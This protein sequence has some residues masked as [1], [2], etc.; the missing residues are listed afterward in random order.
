MLESTTGK[1]SCDDCM[2]LNV[3]LFDEDPTEDDRPVQ[4]VFNTN[5]SDTG[6]PLSVEVSCKNGQWL[7]EENQQQLAITSLS[8]I[9]EP[10][11]TTPAMTTWAP[12]DP[13]SPC[14]K[15]SEEFYVKPANDKIE[16]A[17]YVDYRADRCLFCRALLSANQ[18]QTLCGDPRRW[19]FGGYC[20]FVT[21]SNVPLQ[22]RFSMGSPPTTPMIEPTTRATERQA[23]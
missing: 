15:C 11:P 3:H 6:L 2:E 16:G 18:E 23:P 21:E 22:L 1:M 20:C 7:Y 12:G 19:R 8:C 14:M 9:Y 10:P 13:N 17:V 5:V 4:T